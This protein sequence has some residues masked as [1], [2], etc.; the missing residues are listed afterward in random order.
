MAKVT[1]EDTPTE[2]IV[3]AANRAVT[4]ADSAGRTL[5]LRQPDFN[6]EFRIVEVAGDLAANTT[7]M[8]MINPLLYVASID[9]DPLGFP[10]SKLQIDALIKRVGRSGYLA[11]L[12]GLQEH[13]SPG[14][15][16][17]AR[18]KNSGGTPD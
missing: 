10:D 15:G 16:D 11:V 7:Y 5:S 17:E 1:I 14:G 6:S 8:N 2:A 9:G 13:F 12:K 18:I 4:V 3:N